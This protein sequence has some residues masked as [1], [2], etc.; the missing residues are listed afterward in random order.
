MRMDWARIGS[1]AALAL[2]ASMAVVAGAQA[3]LKSDPV[4][5]EAVRVNNRGVAEMGQQF[6]EKAEADFA[7]AISKDPKL[8]QAAI[9]D[10]I[11]LLYLQKQEEARKVL[12]QAIALDGKNAQVWYV[13]GLV[14]HADN[15]LPAALD[16]FQQAVK[17]DPRDADS[18]YFEGVCYQEMKQFDKAI[19]LFEQTLAINHLQASAEFGLARAMQRGGR[20]DE[21]AAHFKLFQHMK[22]AKVGTPI[23]LAYGE[24]GQYSI[25]SP[26]EEPESALKAMIP[27][28][29]VAQPLIANIGGAW[30]TTG[31]ACMLD[32]TGSGHM[33]LVVT[34]AGDQA[35]RL[36]KNKG[37]GS[38]EE[39]DAIAAGLKAKG[40]AVA[41]AVGDFD[42]DGLNDIAVALDDAVLLF[43][44]LGK[45]KFQ[46]VTA[47]A[48]IT[49]KNHPTGITFVDY[50]HDGDL[51]LLLTGA[52]LTAGGQSNVLWRNN[53]NKTFTEWTEPVGF[54]GTGKTQ[55][56]I[57]TDSPTSTMIAPWILRSLAT[58][59]ARLCM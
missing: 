17:F 57:L 42:G 45:G 47:D 28:K 19:E 35:I 24:Q 50:D 9:N 33:D 53:G 23:G 16:A 26:V 3:S 11:A 12:R 4:R 1:V 39:F 51:D 25:V 38:F 34:Q 49:A 36:L 13:L 48:G 21:V 2:L 54:E 46:D 40:H 58:A 22:D 30:T 8:A 56:A 29:M 15:N 18:Y 7:L 6:T 32:A 44:N 59:P 27:V 5:A 52:P 55:A 10:G 37:D 43:R 14:E 41:C 31:G 20:K